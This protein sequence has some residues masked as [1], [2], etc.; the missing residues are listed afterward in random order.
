[1]LKIKKLFSIFGDNKFKLDNILF[2]LFPSFLVSGPFLTDLFV[3][4]CSIIFLYFSI[5]EK[6][7]N[8]LLNKYVYFFF[9]I[10]FYF[11]IN[12]LFL[13]FN[14]ENI[15]KVFFYFRFFFF[16][17]AL[18]YFFN[19]N[20]NLI[21]CLYFGFIFVY[22]ILVF[23]G[24]YQYYFKQN[25][26]GWPISETF[27]VSSFFG[28]ELVLGSF[29][30]R[31]FPIV[32]GL[33]IYLNP[34]KNKKMYTLFILFICVEVLIF[35][36]GER[37]SFFYLNLSALFSI[38]LLNN[39]K[40]LR[41]LILSISILLILIISNFNDTAKKRIVDKTINQIGIDKPEAKNNH[42]FKYQ[43][44]GYKF[45]HIFSKQHEQHY[46]S[47]LKMYKDN[48]FFGI[49]INNF[50]NLCEHQKY[51]ISEISCSTHPHNTYIQL[52]AETGIIGLFFIALILFIF[53]YFS[54]KHLL[55][56]LIFKKIIFTD[57]EI[58]IL[59]SI[60]ITIWPL[61]PTGN[62]FN[63]WLSTIYYL[64]VGLLIWS[65]EKKV[66]N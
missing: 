14:N 59:S 10:Y 63:N 41:M 15:F 44:F 54:L 27:R 2:F 22:L 56:K 29:L 26:L 48:K 47:A 38:I 62:F 19:K 7:F 9:V 24:F 46:L 35:L 28:D 11:L 49:G 20:S 32:F 43:I 53:I 61:V 57:F 4:F 50:R 66:K 60:L 34:V 3:T 13:N 42:Q 23:D 40:V 39:F 8:Y 18:V 65:L 37:A 51:K 36:S 31:T 25:I 12:A 17:L 16:S 58:L 55:N 6:N 45:N 33:H 30:S 1:M 64:P 5:K 52:L 21:K